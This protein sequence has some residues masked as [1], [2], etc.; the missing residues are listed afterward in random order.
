MFLGRDLRRGG[1]S[2]FLH[3][4]LRSDAA[5]LR[6]RW[7]HGSLVAWLSFESRHQSLQVGPGGGVKISK[8]KN[9]VTHIPY[10][11]PCILFT[12]T[13]ICMCHS[14]YSLHLYQP[15]WYNVV[16][17]LFERSGILI[18]RSYHDPTVDT[19]QLKPHTV[20]VSPAP[21]KPQ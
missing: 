19:S 13:Y 4:H 8:S 3:G 10:C 7:G 17:E 21:R 5:R 18:A 6:A 2:H 14:M 15:N 11:A 20:Y 12:Y 1:C 16:P 9:S